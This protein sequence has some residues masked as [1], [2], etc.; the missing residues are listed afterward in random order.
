MS[1]N[2]SQPRITKREAM[3]RSTKQDF[4]QDLSDESL[5]ALTLKGES[6]AYT[7]LYFR[8]KEAIMKYYVSRISDPIWAEDLMQKSF[9]KAAL[10]LKSFDPSRNFKSWFFTLAHNTMI[11]EL[12]KRAREKDHLQN[13]KVH[14]EALAP[15]DTEEWAHADLEPSSSGSDLKTLSSQAALTS[16]QKRALELRYLHEQSFESIAS[17]LNIKESNARKIISRAL[18]ALK[19]KKA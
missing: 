3:S 5:V 15:S 10:A 11:D 18:K 6:S 1:Q 12:R 9:L 19:A 13:Y 7:Q 8:Y 17:E 2:R 4:Y 16:T 14:L